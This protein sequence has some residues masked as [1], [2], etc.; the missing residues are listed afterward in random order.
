MKTLILAAILFTSSLAQATE[1]EQQVL[2]NVS[3]G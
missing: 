3:S 1:W 2:K